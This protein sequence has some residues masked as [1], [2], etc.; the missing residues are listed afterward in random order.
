MWRG[1]GEYGVGSRSLPRILILQTQASNNGIAS[2]HF[3]LLCCPLSAGLPP[4]PFS[5]RLVLKSSAVDVY[6]KGQS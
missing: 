5:G 6:G 1:E 2:V 4:A 3:L